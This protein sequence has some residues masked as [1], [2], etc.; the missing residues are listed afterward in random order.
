MVKYVRSPW[1]TKIW[2]QA[3]WCKS[4]LIALWVTRNG[5]ESSP[6][7]RAFWCYS[8][9]VGWVPSELSVGLLLA[10]HDYKLQQVPFSEA[11]ALTKSHYHRDSIGCPS[12]V[13]HR[14]CF[15]EW[16]SWQPGEMGGLCF[17]I[18]PQKNK[19]EQHPATLGDY[20][21]RAATVGRWIASEDREPCSLGSTGQSTAPAL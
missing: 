18:H 17:T 16:S 19:A 20:P 12:W 13:P 21:T 1:N 9:G 15:K 4:E 11:A 10:N 6:C 3:A 7:T 2:L 8:V 5:S 14:I